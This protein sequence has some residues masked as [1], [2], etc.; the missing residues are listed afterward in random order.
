MDLGDEN[1]LMAL[2][3]ACQEN[4]FAVVQLQLDRGV[5][6]PARDDGQYSVHGTLQKPA[7]ILKLLD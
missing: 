4:Q 1:G 7:V 3:V 5:N 2:H 6:N